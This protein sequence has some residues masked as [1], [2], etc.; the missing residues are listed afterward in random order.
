MKG[1]QSERLYAVEPNRMKVLWDRPITKASRLLGVDAS[2]VYFGGAELSAVDLKS[3]RLLW[4]T[5]VPGGSMEGQV[6]V[7][8]DGLWLAAADMGGLVQV[9]A[10]PPAA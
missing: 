4:A 9:W 1:T 2:A 6:L 3:R 8:P 7:S 5:R 10:I